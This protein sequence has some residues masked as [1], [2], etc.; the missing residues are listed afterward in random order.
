M[1]AYENIRTRHSVRAFKADPIK[2]EMM[3]KIVEA[4]K[5]SPSYQNTQP[6]G[7]VI[8]SGKK[9]EELS[10]ILIDLVKTNAPTT[11]DIPSPTEWPP[12]LEKRTREHGARRLKI[13]GLERDD[14]EGRE[15]LN[16]MNY[17]FYGAP[18]AVF[19]LMNGKLG[20]WSVF[21]MGLFAQ[22]LL[23]AAHSVGV[24]SCIQASV[25]KYAAEIKAFLQ[26]PPEEKLVACISMGYPD[27]D[28]RINTYV[29]LKKEAE[30][31][32]TRYEEE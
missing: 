15:R 24:S 17:E 8:I 25:V 2:K 29:S 20:E 18:C 28:A 9:K 6:W 19:L 31:F 27:P 21:D 13:L 30:D 4:A 10:R 16:L 11:P 14:R 12:E 1:E 23:L 26:I 5:N 32:V 22:N 3:Q 7:M